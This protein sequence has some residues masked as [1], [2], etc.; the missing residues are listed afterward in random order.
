MNPE[1]VVASDASPDLRA[2][3][4][5]VKELVLASAADA[6]RRGYASDF[7]QFSRWCRGRGLIPLPASPETCCLYVAAISTE[8]ALSTIQ[9]RLT[10]I[11]YAHRMAGFTEN[12]ASTENPLLGTLMKG[13]RR[14]KGVAHVQKDPLL[15]SDIRQIVSARKDLLGIRNTALLLIGY[16]GGLRRGELVSLN[17]SDIGWHS[18]GI[19]VRIMKSKTDGV[20]KGRTIG[21]PF[22]TD[23]TTCPVR[24]LKRWL[25]AAGI[26]EADEPIFRAVDRHGRVSR[27]RLTPGSIARIVKA[28]A[29]AAGMEARAANLA[30]HSLRSGHVSQA[31]LAG[32][33]LDEATVMRQTGHTSAEMLRRY[34][35][36]QD[37]FVLNSAAHLGL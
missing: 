1:I 8:L 26:S 37:M 5:R 36:I 30:G 6:S 31:A 23:E 12:P 24:C 14:V 11:G 34:R 17:H 25:D 13:L 2:A 10:S 22:G 7:A 18:D 4:E 19:I 35:R 20:A 32:P 29:R 3:V 28:A 33:G 16:A 21:I 15:T 27:D 9:R